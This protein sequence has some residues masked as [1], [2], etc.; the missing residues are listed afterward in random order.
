MLLDGQK[1]G[2]ILAPMVKIEND[3]IEVMENKVYRNRGVSYE[4]TGVLW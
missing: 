4:N 1:T 3:R 2:T